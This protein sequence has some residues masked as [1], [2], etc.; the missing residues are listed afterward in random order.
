MDA[1]GFLY[2]SL[3]SSIVQLHDSLGSAHAHVQRLVSVV[4]TATVLDE[5]T[6]EEQCSVVRFLWAKDSM[7]R[8]FIK[9]TFPVYG[10]KCLSRKVVHNWVVKFSQGR[11]KVADDARP[12]AQGHSA[13]GRIRSSREINVFFPVSNIGCF[14]FYNHL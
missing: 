12:G 5:F 3:D 13:A 1:I 2:V 9:Q 14:T 10:G 7:Q 8:M 11:S 4:K 6:T